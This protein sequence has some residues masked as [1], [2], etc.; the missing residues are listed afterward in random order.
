M[1][2]L[3]VF[4]LVSFITQLYVLK[5]TYTLTDKG[6]FYF[7]WERA[8]KL[9]VPVWTALV[10]LVGCSV[11][12]VNIVETIIFWVIWLKHYAHSDDNNYWEWYTYWRFKDNFLSRKI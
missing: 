8:E 2:S 6:E 4:G 9:G 1:A 7:C 11:P 3:I 10:I 5:H 12:F